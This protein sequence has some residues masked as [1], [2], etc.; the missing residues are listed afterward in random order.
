MN[1]NAKKWESIAQLY[2]KAKC[3]DS[4]GYCFGRVL[5]SDT[6]NTTLW[7]ERAK[8]YEQTGELK[9]AI[10]CFERVIQKL[11]SKNFDAIK[12]C[13]KVKSYQTSLIN[14]Q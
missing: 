3:Y 12:N 2:K 4:A 9:K 13:A 1:V 5:K 8:C 14:N 7:C 10:K 11:D 6:L